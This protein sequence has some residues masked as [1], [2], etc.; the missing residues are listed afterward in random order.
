MS[1]LR[2]YDVSDE[3][4]HFVELEPCLPAAFVLTS[5]KTQDAFSYGVE[6]LVKHAKVKKDECFF[7]IVCDQ[8]QAQLNSLTSSR[9]YSEI[10]TK[11]VLCELHLRDNFKIIMK[12]KYQFNDHE[13]EASSLL[14]WFGNPLPSR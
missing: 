2:T 12:E 6:Q 11:I 4:L 14:F 3:V 13:V 1:V 9:G 5:S 8:E 10:Y 7:A